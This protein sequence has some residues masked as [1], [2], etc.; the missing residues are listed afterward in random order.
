MLG[1]LIGAAANIAGGIFGKNQEYKRQKEFAQNALQWRAEDAEKAGISKRFAMGAPAISYSPSSVGFG[2][3]SGLG[4]AIDSGI[5]GQG[6]AGST[7]GGKTAGITASIAQAQLDGLRIDNDIKRAELASKLNIAT[8]PGAGGLLDRDTIG[9]SQDTLKLQ[10][11]QQPAG[12]GVGQ[13]SFGVSPEVDMYKTVTGGYAPQ[14]P[15]QLQ[16]A[17]EDDW[18]S[19][20]QWR[21]RNK[22]LPFAFDSYKT[23]PYEAPSGHFWTFDPLL[24]EYRLIKEGGSKTGGRAEGWEYVMKN[25]R[26]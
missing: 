8:Q 7:T 20:W 14:V 5:Q 11:Q 19:L 18:L 23:R 6:G 3:F 1:E 4:K 9:G 24:G 13:K 12:Y 15:Q 10:K 22:I 17:F 21:A 16:E 25:L 26:R 2:D